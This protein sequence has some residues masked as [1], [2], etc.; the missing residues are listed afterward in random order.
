ADLV[1]IRACLTA[2]RYRPAHKK[3]DTPRPG[4]EPVADLSALC[5]SSKFWGRLAAPGI[6]GSQKPI[7]H[8]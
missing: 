5:F 3:P 4:K 2:G 7:R 1:K 8:S 6:I